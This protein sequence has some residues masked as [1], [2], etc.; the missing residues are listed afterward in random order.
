MTPAPLSEA[1]RRFLADDV[2]SVERLDLLLFLYR[3]AQRWW[4]AQ[5][6]A[7]ELEMPAETV[8][9]HLEHLSARN[10]LDV[11]ITEAVVYRYKPGREELAELVEEAVR[12]QYLHRD[13]V[14]A[15]LA[16]P[17]ADSARLFADAFQLRKGKRDG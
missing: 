12:A 15:A 3:Q 14:V 16:Q 1:V 7:G 11:R 10:L 2:G 4:S 8:Q 9:L 5:S 13:T 17:L 6:L